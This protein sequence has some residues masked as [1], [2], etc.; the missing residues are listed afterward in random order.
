MGF[1]HNNSIKLNFV[2]HSAKVVTIIFKPLLLILLSLTVRRKN[3]LLAALSDGGMSSKYYCFLLKQFLH[4]IAVHF[5]YFASD[6]DNFSFGEFVTAVFVD[7]IVPLLQKRTWYNDKSG[8]NWLVHGRH[9][10]D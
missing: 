2:E 5:V 9:A 8:S 10:I 4:I 7:L 6:R 1:V 3:N